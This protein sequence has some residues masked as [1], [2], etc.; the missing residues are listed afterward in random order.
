[1][2]AP[3]KVKGTPAPAPAKAETPVR[4]KAT[5]KPKAEK[6][7][8]KAEVAPPAPAIEE[9]A[10]APAPKAARAKKSSGGDDLTVIEGLGPKS[11]QA[12]HA[13][14]ITTFAQIAA[15]SGDELQEI[16]KVQAKVRILDGQTKTWPKQ[17][18][19]LVE[20]DEAGF[21]SYTEHLVGGREPDDAG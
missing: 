15:M 7:A 9:A 3:P 21:K 4:I 10:P 18:K 2:A 12:L 5:P 1:M 13:A 8:P 14:G 6:P 16:V 19:Y 11:A 20:G 17:A